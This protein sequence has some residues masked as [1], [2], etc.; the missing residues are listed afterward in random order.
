MK[1]ASLSAEGDPADRIRELVEQSE[2]TR[3]VESTRRI[4]ELY[5]AGQKPQA[6][7]DAK[8][9]SRSL[10]MLARQLDSLYRG[11]IAPELASLLDI[12]KRVTELSDE[13]KN[14]QPGE[15]LAEWRRIAEALIRD[16]EKA[17]F[18]ESARA[19]SDLVA[20]GGNGAVLGPASLRT[21]LSS[22][23]ATLRNKIQELLLKDMIS[24][25]DEATPPAFKE[26]VERYYEVLST[27]TNRQ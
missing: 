26:L 7:R 13:L 14:A 2:A 10:E 27:T 1:D 24:A 20:A 15:N 8:N 11:I 6:R 9:L 5:A 22:V 19:L 18:T 17:G 4:G 23:S 25:R 16:L 3:V 21:T 12:D